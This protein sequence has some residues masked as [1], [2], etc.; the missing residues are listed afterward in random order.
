MNKM[1]WR[2]YKLDIIN[3]N[4]RRNWLSKIWLGVLSVI[5][6][7]TYSSNPIISYDDQHDGSMFY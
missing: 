4:V 1:N 3:N 7:F 2:A 5:L 6:S